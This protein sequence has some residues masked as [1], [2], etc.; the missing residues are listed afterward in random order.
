MKTIT[1]AAAKGGAGKTT[2]A[3]LL[4]VQA[5]RAA[6]IDLNMD[7]GNLTQ[8]WLLR[9]EPDDPRLIR[10]VEDLAFD[11]KALAAGRD[12]DWLFI[13]T[14]PLDMAL[15]AEAVAVAD[16]VVIPV[17]ASIFD[18]STV[19]PLVAMC[20][21]RGKPFAFVLSAAD[22]KFR[23]LTA[24]AQAA[25]AQEGPVLGPRLSY[26]APYV[27]ALTRGL[28]GPETHKDLK[29]EAAALWAEI[30]ALAETGVRA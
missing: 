24:Q 3:A 20:R 7:Q 16:A 5:G 27:Q 11:V 13:D 12:F 8:W 18:V 2:L 28:T 9:G 19:D 29:P 10:N 23:T 22:P 14:P 26:R 25:L 1:V 4:A 30:R 17:R 15:I 21:S 6:L